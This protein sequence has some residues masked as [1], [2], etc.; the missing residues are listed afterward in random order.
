MKISKRNEIDNR[1]NNKRHLLVLE[2]STNYIPERIEEYDKDMFV[3]F[4]TINQKY[5]IHS[6]QYPGDTYQMTV[7]F[8]ELDN[9]ILKHVWQNDISVHGKE[10]FKRIEQGEE[11]AKKSKDREFKNW[12]QGVAS[13]TKSMFAKDAWTNL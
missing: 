8:D 13:E 12:V 2:G 11:K 9:R 4:N 3:V 1:L 7:P 5:E 10:I 6:I